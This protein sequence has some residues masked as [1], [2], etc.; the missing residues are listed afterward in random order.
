MSKEILGLHKLKRSDKYTAE[1]I[2]FWSAF[3]A[4]NKH[5]R[6]QQ[7]AQTRHGTDAM[8]V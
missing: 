5:W 4:S 1:L 7:L 8:M 3:E 2:S 6:R